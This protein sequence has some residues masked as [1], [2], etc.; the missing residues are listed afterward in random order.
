M[1]E[2]TNICYAY[3]GRQVLKDICLQTSPG[4]TAVIG[5]NAAGKTTFIKCLAGIFRPTGS[6][7]IDG[8]PV[9]KWKRSDLFDV[10]GY[11]PQQSDGQA[12]ISVFEAVLLGRLSS[13]SW[14][15]DD[16]DLNIVYGILHELGLDHLASKSMSELSGGQQQMVS[17]AQ[18]LAKQPRILLM[19]EPTNN[20]DL[21][22]Q[23][24]V[25]EVISLLTEERGLTTV[26]ALHDLNFAA[27]FAQ[28]LVVL[29]QGKL[30]ATGCPREVLTE[31]L[32]HD[33]YGVEARVVIDDGVPQIIPIRSRRR[34]QYS[35]QS[36]HAAT[37]E[38]ACNAQ[39]L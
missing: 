12:L 24:E 23:L 6:M 22:R 28:T 20:L 35:R 4:L 18:S 19:D 3:G 34:V 2:A 25:F 21:Q 31:A 26:M 39:G 30:I 33:L 11:L 10:I 8:K 1:I 9:E 15:V 37:M 16:E 29:D 38:G 32:L 14:R 13:L 17:I 5:P 27:R 7:M 36:G